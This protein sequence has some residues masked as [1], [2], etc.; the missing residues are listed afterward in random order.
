[1]PT[2]FQ[3]VR[4][5]S[6]NKATAA[7]D[8]DAATTETPEPTMK[9][10]L[11]DEHMTSSSDEEPPAAPQPKAAK[12]NRRQKQHEQQQQQQQQLNTNDRRRAPRTAPQ[13]RLQRQR[14]LPTSKAYGNF[15]L[16]CSNGTNPGE[17]LANSALKNRRT[18]RSEFEGNTC[19]VWLDDQVIGEATADN[20][21]DAKK[22]ANAAAVKE[23]QKVCYT[24]VVS[25]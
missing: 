16:M 21:L 11:R 10:M 14:R 7:T 20:K 3:A 6:A 12:A 24:I 5:V 25:V 4:F 19:T 13:V 15:V 2:H 8:D 23:L 22:L 9:P 18:L 1:M 17:M